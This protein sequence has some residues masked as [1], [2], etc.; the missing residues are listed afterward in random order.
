MPNPPAADRARLALGRV[1]GA[2][3]AVVAV[4]PGRVN[5]IGEHTDYND[6]LVMPIAI[7]QCC[8]V[9][10]A[11]RDDGLLRIVAAD[12][13]A[14]GN[15]SEYAFSAPSPDLRGCWQAYVLGP[16]ALCAARASGRAGADVAIASDVP[17]GAGLS[18]SAAAEVAVAT[19]LLAMWRVR[20]SPL[21]LRN[22]ASA[23][24]TSSRACRAA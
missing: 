22:C 13:P 1:L 2:R 16:A 5:L 15:T 10:A 6:G 11:P 3:P 19:A 18:S 14:P 9:A 24:S 20:L 8:A 23:P 21:E 4:A 17:M 7:A 12:L